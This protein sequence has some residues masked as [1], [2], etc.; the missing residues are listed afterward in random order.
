MIAMTLHDN[1]SPKT[2]S[3][4]WEEDI[5]HLYHKELAFLSFLFCDKGSTKSLIGKSFMT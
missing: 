2:I 1:V 3:Q 5:S 4:L